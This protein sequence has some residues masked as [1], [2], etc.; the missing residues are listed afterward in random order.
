M[1]SLTFNILSQKRSD[2]RKFGI[3][4][5]HYLYS[6]M[7]KNGG[8][9]WCGCRGNRCFVMKGFQIIHSVKVSPIGTPRHSLEAGCIFTEFFVVISVSI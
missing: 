9:R 6:I 4:S 2:E 3:E 8:N 5:L 1:S 7:S